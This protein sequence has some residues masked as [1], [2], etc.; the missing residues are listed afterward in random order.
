MSEVK[1]YKY[2]RFR[3]LFPQ[4]LENNIK[5]KL[6][7][8]IPELKDNFKITKL[9]IDVEPEVRA[10]SEKEELEMITSKIMGNVYLRGRI[11]NSEIEVD[12]D[13]L[14][15]AIDK[16]ITTVF[17]ENFIPEMTTFIVDTMLGYNGFVD[18][19][20]NVY[21]ENLRMTFT[22]HSSANLKGVQISYDGHFSATIA[23]DPEF[24]K[25][26]LEKYKV[27]IYKKQGRG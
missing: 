16:I 11:T 18:K 23:P 2:S 21:K 27:T 9:M 3:E 4:I 5:E 7:Q 13:K 25:N 17:F 20:K 26:E 15:K 12:K 14:K 6:F 19:Y 1:I 10:L 22:Y 24:W 8:E